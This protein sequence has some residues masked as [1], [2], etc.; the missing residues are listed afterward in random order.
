M[1]KH[2]VVIDLHDRALCNILIHSTRIPT[3]IPS[4]SM[5]SKPLGNSRTLNLGTPRSEITECATD[6]F[7]HTRQ[8]LAQLTRNAPPGI[9]TDF[10][11]TRTPRQLLRRHRTARKIYHAALQTPLHAHRT[12]THHPLRISIHETGSLIM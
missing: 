10:P 9:Q 7:G 5:Q 11:A 12:P 1:K 2:K 8:E 4:S 6:S 3:R